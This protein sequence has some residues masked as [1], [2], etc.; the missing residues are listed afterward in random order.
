ME[1]W[2]DPITPFVWLGGGV[3]LF[4]ILLIF[5]FVL[6]KTYVNRIRKEEQ[7]KH[8]LE[9]NYQKQLLKTNI[10]TQEQERQRIADEL[11]DDLIAQLYRIKLINTN[12]VI[13]VMLKE[14]IALIRRTS[15]KLSPPLIEHTLLE[16][17]LKGFIK[18]YH[19]AYKLQRYFSNSGEVLT[20]MYKLNILR[21]FQEVVTN[22]HKH[23]QADHISVCYRNTKAY[24]CL[25]VKDDGLG[26]DLAKKTGLG[27]KSIE[28][29]VQVLNG[30]FKFKSNE[31][32]GT[33]F[34][35]VIKN[36]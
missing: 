10:D 21:I 15:H 31:S 35:L 6:I 2:K 9:L 26:I 27:M 28:S 36:G 30:Q 1:N 20:N 3:V 19:K 18:P 14:G 24:I 8:K 5:I 22:I 4:L 33:T 23:A 11:H 12:E 34:I 17:L 16:D 7:H 13:N 29:R 32:N 25:V